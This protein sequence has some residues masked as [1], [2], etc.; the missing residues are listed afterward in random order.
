MRSEPRKIPE[1]GSHSRCLPVAQRRAPTLG[2]C[3]P[4]ND[5]APPLRD[6]GYWLT[7]LRRLS[8]A[9]HSHSHLRAPVRAP[10]GLQGTV[11]SIWCLLT[12]KGVLAFSVRLPRSNF[13]FPG[14]LAAPAVDPGCRASRSGDDRGG[15]TLQLSS[16]LGKLRRSAPGRPPES[17]SSGLPC[18][19]P[20][21]QI[22]PG[23]RGLESPP[24]LAY[25]EFCFKNESIPYAADRPYSV[26]LCDTS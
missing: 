26:C 8:T 7:P 20:G 12:A 17:A 23:L 19:R 1:I 25:S 10:E 13:R 9:L 21:A 5:A 2:T 24:T 22:P 15:D 3:R 6:V 4:G 16:R 11:G 18:W 14:S